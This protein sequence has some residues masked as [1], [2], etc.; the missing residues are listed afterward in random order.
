MHDLQDQEIL[1]HAEFFASSD[2]PASW[3]SRQGVIGSHTAE[4]MSPSSDASSLQCR[5]GSLARLH[6]KGRPPQACLLSARTKQL[7]FATHHDCRARVGALS[8]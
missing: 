2:T 8:M 7:P 4:E 5:L 3:M 1:P 6:L